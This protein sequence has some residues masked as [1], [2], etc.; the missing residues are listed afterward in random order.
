MSGRL[1][2]DGNDGV[3]PKDGSEG[4]AAGFGKFVNEPVFPNEGTCG[5]GIDGGVLGRL[6]TF[7]SSGT[8]NDPLP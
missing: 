8:L 1:G 2:T 6:G 5:V 7:G 4:G 3:A